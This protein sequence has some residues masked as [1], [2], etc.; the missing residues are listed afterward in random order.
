[1]L[2]EEIDKIFRIVDHNNNGVIDYTEFITSAAN[3]SELISDKQL[4]A[5]FKA[6]DLDGSGEISY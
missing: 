5:A 2:E 4:K 6:I 3:I 1:M